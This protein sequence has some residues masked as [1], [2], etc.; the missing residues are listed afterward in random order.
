MDNF[1]YFFY[2]DVWDPLRKSVNLPRLVSF[3]LEFMPVFQALFLSTEEFDNLSFT[4]S[5]KF[6]V[7]FLFLMEYLQHD[8]VILIFNYHI[9]FMVPMWVLAILNL[10]LSLRIPIV[11][12][13]NKW[14]TF[15]MVF[16][17][18]LCLNDF[19]SENTSLI[20][21]YHRRHG[22]PLSLN[23]DLSSIISFVLK[24]MPLLQDTRNSC[25]FSY[26]NLQMTN[27]F[28]L[29]VTLVNTVELNIVRNGVNLNIERLIP[30]WMMSCTLFNFCLSLRISII[31]DLHEWVHLSIVMGVSESFGF[32]NEK[33]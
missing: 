13:S 23:V 18:M 15:A 19:N 4:I 12:N 28:I 32:N 10:G 6:V 2:N 21:L 29:F 16:V 26:A 30:G 27:L 31:N 17:K 33:S 25:D 7:S 14:M 1:H 8:F 22:C 11:Q 9:N 3:E 20:N 24:M 5:K